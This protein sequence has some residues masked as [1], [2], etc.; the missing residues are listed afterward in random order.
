MNFG[1]VSGKVRKNFSK[2]LKNKKNSDASAA[3][4]LLV[5]FGK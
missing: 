4:K 5:S 2:R 1:N 3:V